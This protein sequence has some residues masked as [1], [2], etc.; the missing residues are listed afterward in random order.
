M[1]QSIVKKE[2]TVRPVFLLIRVYANNFLKIEL[3]LLTV[4]TSNFIGG[5]K[6]KRCIHDDIK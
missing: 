3:L 6:F 1:K 5:P 2:C 4:G